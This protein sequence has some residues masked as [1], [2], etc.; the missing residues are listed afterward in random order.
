MFCCHSFHFAFHFSFYYSRSDLYIFRASSLMIFCAD[1]KRHVLLSFCAYTLYY[2]LSYNV[3]YDCDAY[4]KD[5]VSMDASKADNIPNTMEKPK[6]HKLVRRCRLHMA[7][8]SHSHLCLLLL[9]RLP[10]DQT[11]QCCD[12]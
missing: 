9:Q 11:M 5:R 8:T 2:T 7:K 1:H 10:S 12:V 6:L 4:A 3:C